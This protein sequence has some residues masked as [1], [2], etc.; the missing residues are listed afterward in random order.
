[1]AHVEQ[2]DAG[3]D[4]RAQRQ[5][6][7]V[8]D[9]F[10]DAEDRQQEE[11]GGGNE[12]CAQRDLPAVAHVQHHG[13]GEEGVEAHAGGQGDRVVGD[14]AHDGRADGR[15][16]AGGDEHRALVH[17]GLAEDARVDEE[18]VGHGQEG[19]DPRQ[20]LGAHRGVVRL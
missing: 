7:A 2:A 8:D 20:D 4:R 10:A 3:G 15:C 19:G 18:D 1:M 13:V 6:D 16:Q 12:H 9:P 14:Q 5:G 11:H 17:A